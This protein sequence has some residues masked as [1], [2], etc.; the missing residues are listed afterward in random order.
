MRGLSLGVAL[1]IAFS[2]A[3]DPN[4]PAM[5]TLVEPTADVEESVNDEQ[6]TAHTDLQDQDL[7]D[8][9]NID[10]NPT[11][12][13]QPE[14]TPQP[15]QVPTPTRKIGVQWVVTKA[16]KA[17]LR[18]LGYS[19]DEVNKLD[20]ERASAII[21]KSIRRP[22]RGVPDAWN[23]RK[24][25]RGPLAMFRKCVFGN[26]LVSIA[27]LLASGLTT[28]GLTHQGVFPQRARSKLAPPMPPPPPPAAT[29]TRRRRP[30]SNPDDLWLDRK[31][32]ETGA[33]L[34]DLYDN[35]RNR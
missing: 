29:T 33:W 30:A 1:L 13:A 9:E 27:L 24:Q 11:L 26:P 19:T 5:H 28:A 8:D 7:Q 6:S 32:D 12:E 14:P 25:S 17:Q 18:A 35:A 31:I 22:I 34:M 15:P 21:D 10:P 23:R 3:A 4:D 16:M 2:C 20:P